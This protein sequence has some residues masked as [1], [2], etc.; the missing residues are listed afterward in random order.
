MVTPA[1]PMPANYDSAVFNVDLAAFPVYILAMTALI[2]DIAS[3]V[4]DVATVINNLTLGWAGD[5]AD[6]VSAFFDSWNAAVTV[7]VGNGDPNATPAQSGTLNILAGALTAAMTNYD[8]TETILVTQFSQF[9]QAL[10]GGGSA[11][12]QAPA[13]VSDKLI[14][15]VG[16]TFSD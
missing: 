11:K 10:T 16:E 13:N 9:T 8:Q 2:D 5:T 6:E 4:A 15:A 1:A 3:D 7:L 12:N 14:S